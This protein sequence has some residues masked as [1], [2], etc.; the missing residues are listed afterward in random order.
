MGASVENLIE[1]GGSVRGVRY[2]TGHDLRELRVAL[3]VGADGRFS[4][5]RR[6]SGCE[7][8]RTEMPTDTLWLRLPLRAVNVIHTGRIYVGNGRFMAMANRG[9]YWQIGYSLEKGKYKQ[10][11][12]RG[13][14]AFRNSIVELA[15]WLTSTI[16]ELQDWKQTSL[17]SVEISRVSR[18][19]RPGLLLIGDAAHVMSPVF[20]VG[21]NYAIQDAVVAA[22][23]VGPR[24]QVGSLSIQD[25]AQVQLRR[26]FATRVMQTLQRLAVRL[27]LSG[28]QVSALPL[29][30]RPLFV[31]EVALRFRSQVVGLGLFRVGVACEE[32]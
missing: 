13:I 5:V 22:N 30:A 27:F 19:Y 14:D 1:E 26:E 24:L 2:R 8:I 7:V 6:L 11:R 23:V 17:L 21:I 29:L 32:S 18:W 9:S 10:L 15:P 20:G 31:G 25:L 3:V 4:T 28:G 16:D 12:S